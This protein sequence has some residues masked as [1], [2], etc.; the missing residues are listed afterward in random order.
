MISVPTAV[1]VS[2][3]A[4]VFSFQGGF[5]H[6]QATLRHPRQPFFMAGFELFRKGKRYS[7]LGRTKFQPDCQHFF[8][9]CNPEWQAIAHIAG[10]VLP[11]AKPQQTI[12]CRLLPRHS[13]VRFLAYAP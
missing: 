8:C 1:R 11:N 13:L 7:L 12:P 10:G 4:A 6:C 9:W 3:F 5:F 2:P